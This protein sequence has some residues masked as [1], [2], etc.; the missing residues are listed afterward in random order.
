MMRKGDRFDLYTIQGKIA[1]GTVSSVE[2]DANE[3]VLYK[4]NCSNSRYEN[5][6]LLAVDAS[7]NVVPRKVEVLPTNNA[8][9]LDVVKKILASKGL[10]KAKPHIVQLL[11]GDIN[12]NGQNEVVIVATNL[13]PWRGGDSAWDLSKNFTESGAPP[14]APAQSYSM[15]IVRQLEGGSVKDRVIEEYITKKETGPH[16]TDWTPPFLQRV[17]AFADLNGDGKMEMIVANEMYEGISYIVYEQQRNGSWKQ[18]LQNGYG[19]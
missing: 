17:E 14:G 13:S 1:D 12:G 18:V 16:V 6:P 7:H 5:S 19:A 9:Y 8:V 3:T 11:R 2:K 15:V 4:M 10:N